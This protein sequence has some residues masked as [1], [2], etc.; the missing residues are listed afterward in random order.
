MAELF[1]FSAARISLVENVIRPSL[2]EGTIVICDRY[3]Y[4]TL[5][6]QGYG[7]GV[8]R[9]IIENVNNLATKGLKPDLVVLLDLP[10]ELGLSLIHI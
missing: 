7:R 5:S 8:D 9:H 2:Q 10:V 3:I 6:Y 4:S 1:L